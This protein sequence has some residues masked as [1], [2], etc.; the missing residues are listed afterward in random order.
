MK[1]S[2]LTVLFL[3]SVVSAA[4]LPRDLQ[5]FQNVLA[6]VQTD[7]D[8]LD[9]AVNAYN[10]NVTPVSDR[11]DDLIATIDNGNGQLVGQPQLSLSDTLI[12]NDDVTD[13]KAHAR[14]LVDDLKAKRGQVIADGHCALVR[15]KISD[16][17][18]SANTLIDTI[19]SKVDPAAKSIAEGQARDIRAILQ[20][21]A[22]AYNTANCP[23]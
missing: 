15:D 20:D 13:F 21:A 9:A 2:Q 14:T 23:S 7:T 11:A 4:V 18:D 5:A 3:A 8:E 12:L 1:F 22:D 17:S 6:A 16:I 10:G 19:V